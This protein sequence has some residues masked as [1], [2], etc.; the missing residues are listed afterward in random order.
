MADTDRDPF[1]EGKLA[2]SGG[3]PIEANPYPAGSDEY[4]LWAAGHEYVTGSAEHG[5]PSEDV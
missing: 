4:G 1:E 5:E 3:M 2:A